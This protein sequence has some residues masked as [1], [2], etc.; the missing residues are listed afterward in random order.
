MEFIEHNGVKAVKR[1]SRD[2]AA[3]MEYPRSVKERFVLPLLTDKKLCVPRLLEIGEDF[4]IQEFIDGELLGDIYKGKTLEFQDIDR[5]IIDQIVDNI[6]GLAKVD[7]GPLEQRM[8]WKNNQEFFLTQLNN[9]QKIFK[10]YYG[11]LGTIYNKLN[12]KENILDGFYNRATKIDNAR[13]M[14]LI[15]GDRHKEN[16]IL[17]NG[18]VYFIDWELAHCGDLAY[19]IAFHL[20]QMDY[21]RQDEKYFLESIRQKLPPQQ[22]SSMNDLDLYRDFCMA[23]SALFHVYHTDLYY[24]NKKTTLNYDQVAHFTK[25]YNMLDQ[26]IKFGAKPKTPNQVQNIFK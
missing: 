4:L 2:F 10:K 15:H 1:F 21:S 18:Q 14:V 9:T 8:P 3:D 16:M 5:R 19:D 6:V 7:A 22:M 11:Q 25:R 12:I 26:R 17:K 24:T 20:H 13:P 23:R